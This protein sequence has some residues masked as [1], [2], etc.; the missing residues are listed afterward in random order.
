M[1]TL[2][3]T[4]AANVIFYIDLKWLILFCIEFYLQ[5]LQQ[6]LLYIDFNLS[7]V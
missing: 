7:N 6:M 5:Y 4:F 2:N 1:L 3:V